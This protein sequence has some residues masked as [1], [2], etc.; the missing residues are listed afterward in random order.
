MF[1]YSSLSEL[2]ECPFLYKGWLQGPP[3]HGICCPEDTEKLSP[4]S[5]PQPPPHSTS[6]GN[7]TS[8]HERPDCTALASGIWN[9]SWCCYPQYG[10]RRCCGHAHLSSVMNTQGRT[11]ENKSVQ[12]QQAGPSHLKIYNCGIRSP[13]DTLK[14]GMSATI[15]ASGATRKLVNC[16]FN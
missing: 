12:S 7:T 8:Q 16:L 9:S 5:L 4:V 13:G 3:G 15:N 14:Y 11:G 1:C 2:R 6:R 10:M